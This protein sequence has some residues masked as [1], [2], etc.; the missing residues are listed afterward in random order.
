MVYVSVRSR[1]SR[2][3]P[4]IEIIFT[5]EFIVTV[6]PH[7]RLSGRRG[8][9]DRS[10]S[11]VGI[12]NHRLSNVEAAMSS[13]MDLGSYHKRFKLP[14]DIRRSRMCLVN[15]HTPKLFALKYGAP[16]TALCRL[17]D[18]AMSRLSRSA[19]SPAISTNSDD[20]ISTSAVSSL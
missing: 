19:F 13:K 5:R 16:D 7:E 12:S 18:A 17:P 8:Q 4:K 1:D 2:Q 9:A 14:Q 10:Q 20:S 11:S 3:H 6:E 15:R